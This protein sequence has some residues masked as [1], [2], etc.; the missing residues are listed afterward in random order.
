M[1]LKCGNQERQ[2]RVYS[3]GFHCVSNRTTQGMRAR[4]TEFLPDGAA[5]AP[6][7]GTGVRLEHHH[8]GRVRAHGPHPALDGV[9]E[10]GV[11]RRRGG[12]AWTAYTY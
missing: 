5:S 2:V 9:A 12:K 11:R 4:R 7:G 10:A 1:Y 3:I 6:A 8:A